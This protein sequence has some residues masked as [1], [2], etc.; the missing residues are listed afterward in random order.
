MTT[1]QEREG[2]SKYQQEVLDAM[3]AEKHN[4]G[5]SEGVFRLCSLTCL[6]QCAPTAGLAGRDGEWATM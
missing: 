3:L 1:R 6:G 5:A 4:K 2:N